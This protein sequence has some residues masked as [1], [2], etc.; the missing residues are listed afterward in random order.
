MLLS[1]DCLRHCPRSYV[2]S[3]VV[4]VITEIFQYALATDQVSEVSGFNERI[5]SWMATWNTQKVRMVLCATVSC[6]IVV[7]RRC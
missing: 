3:V 7:I 4:V 6:A 2:Y 5:E 1:Y